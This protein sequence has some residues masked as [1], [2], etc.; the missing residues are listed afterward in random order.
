MEK[1]NFQIIIAIVSILFLCNCLVV[2]GFKEFNENKIILKNN[3]DFYFVHLTDT[4][5][6]HKI[7]DFQ[8]N[9]KAKLS[10]ILNHVISFEKKPA[11]IVITGDLTEWGGSGLTGALNCKA[12]ADC[13]YEKNG[14]LYADED[15][16]IPVYTTPGNHDYSYYRN[17]N[18]YHMFI[19]KNH[20]AEKDKYIVTHGNVSLFFMDS[21][22]NYFI[23]PFTW[24]DICGY[25]L[26]DRDIEWLDDAFNNSTQKKIVLMHHPAVNTRNKWGFVGGVLVRNR[27]NFIDLCEKYDTELVLAGHTHHAVIYD[28]N[29][30]LYNDFPLN[31]S[32]YS[33]LYVQSDDCKEGIHYRNISIIGNNIWVEESVELET[34]VLEQNIIEKSYEYIFLNIER[35]IFILQEQVNA[36]RNQES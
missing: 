15:H 25:G 11:F 36:N 31:S 18:N 17:L 13:F 30:D 2:V 35:Y 1:I 28:K 23:N 27:E 24:F 32:L 26:K 22:P 8:E 5:I 20:I 9:T 3:D 6:R 4:H 19:D 14:Q 12:F 7:F 33:T 29:L 10:S 16:L 34:T 21:G